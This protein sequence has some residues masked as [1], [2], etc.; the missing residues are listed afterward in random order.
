MHCPYCGQE[1]PDSARFCPTTGKIL[2][3]NYLTCPNCGGTVKFGAR[4]CP[5]CG[6][7]FITAVLQRKP[8]LTKFLPFAAIFLVIVATGGFLFWR[9]FVL[10]GG[11]QKIS[12]LGNASASTTVQSLNAG[13]IEDELQVAEISTEAPSIPTETLLQA[14]PIPSSKTNTSTPLLSPTQEQII[15]TSTSRPTNTPIPSE[16]P[17]P[18]PSPQT[19]DNADLVFIPAGEFIMGSDPENDPYFYGAEGPSHKVYLNSYWI[20]RTEV[21]NAMYQICEQQ[22]ACPLPVRFS[23][24]TRQQYYYEPLFANY[25]VVYVSWIHARAYC[26]WAGGRL[27]TEAE[28]EK[29]ARGTDGRLF[30]WGNQPPSSELV[31]SGSQDTVS[32]GS[33]PAGASPFGVLDMSGNVIEWVFDYFQA[34]YYSVSPYENP[35]GPALGKT[36]VYRGGSYQN[37]ASSVQIVMRGSRNESH[38]NVDIGFRCVIDNP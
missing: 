4:F 8:P 38:A 37:D 5:S 20:Y 10:F 23:S 6:F 27:P 34:T 2:Q 28:W 30:S 18:F 22:D 26:Q 9:M 3:A 29:A 7:S 12:F 1:H 14:T 33:Y 19:V 36:R 13:A 35:R 21:T 16:T 24:N 31:N 11:H 25:P 32:V 15:L 17:T